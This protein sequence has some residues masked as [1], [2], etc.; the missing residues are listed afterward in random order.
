[1]GDEGRLSTSSD[2]LQH[3]IDN[4]LRL[5]GRYLVADLEEYR[6]KEE[7]LR[8]SVVLDKLKNLSWND[9]EK[10]TIYAALKLGMTYRNELKRLFGKKAQT[11]SDAL[12]SL[13]DKGLIEVVEEGPALAVRKDYLLH[14]V[15]GMSRNTVERTILCRLTTP[16]K[17]FLANSK[18]EASLEKEVGK[19]FSCKVQQEAARFNQVVKQVQAV[20]N[21][22]VEE[23]QAKKEQQTLQNRLSRKVDELIVQYGQDFTGFIEEIEQLMRDNPTQK[24]FLATKKRKL[25][26][27]YNGKRD[28]ISWAEIIRQ[29]KRNLGLETI[30]GV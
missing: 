29:K 16:A 6:E 19:L 3:S 10:K 30:G 14:N 9:S 1:M 13:A 15:N 4:I 28:R 17:A 26:E 8:L 7:E 22:D 25:T 27:Y 18:V 24:Q 23:E 12:N 5:V 21:R 2:N 20:R 11:F